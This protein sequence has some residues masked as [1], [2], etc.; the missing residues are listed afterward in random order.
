MPEDRFGK[1]AIELGLVTEDQLAD[2]VEAM[3]QLADMG[4]TE[5]L[6]TIMVKKGY[7]TRD[8]VKQVLAAQGKRTT[9]TIAGYE[10]EAKIGQGAMGAVYRA[11]QTSMD[12]TVALKVLPPSLARDK[13][14]TD[15][16]LTEARA[17]ARLNHPNIIQ[18]IDVGQA[19]KYYYFAMEYVDGRTVAERLRETGPMAEAEAVSVARQVAEALEHASHQGI[20]HR[21]IKPDNIMITADGMAKLCDLGLAKRGK[22]RDP[23][24]EGTA[25]GTPHY[26]SPEQAKGEV[27]VDA[28]SDIYSLG[29]TLY[30]MLTGKPPFEGNTA[31]VVMTKHLTE[32]LPNPQDVRPDLSDGAC[33]VIE[34]MMAKDPDDRYQWPRDLLADLK[35][36]EAGRAP[37]S[38][39]VEAGR[40]SVMRAAKRRRS[41]RRIETPPPK[42]SATPFIAAAAGAVM[43]LG[44]VAVLFWPAKPED[45]PP[46]PRPPRPTPVVEKLPPKP[47]AV[48]AATAADAA[49]GMFKAAKDYAD[50]HPQ[51]FWSI[52]RRYMQVKAETTGTKYSLMADDEL[53]SHQARQKRL[54]DER[55]A[56]C[57]QKSGPLEA[58]D[59]FAEAKKLFEGFQQDLLED[60]TPRASFFLEKE[61]RRIDVAAKRRHAALVK[62]AAGRIK[63]GKLDEAA[64]LIARAKRI[65]YPEYAK[66]IP[67][68]E[69]A[70]SDARK[71]AGAAAAAAAER[72][73]RA[74]F[75]AERNRILSLGREKR[76]G[77]ALSATDA[78]LANLKMSKW[79][80]ELRQIES[81]LKAVVDRMK[82][83]LEVLGERARDGKAVTIHKRGVL[84]RNAKIVSVQG[85][86][87]TVGLRAMGQTTLKLTDLSAKDVV[88]LT[89]LGTYSQ[90]AKFEYGL[91]LFF[92][93]RL[94]QAKPQ[95]QRASE[96]G[97]Y[98]D[99]AKYFL[100]LM[101]AESREGREKRAAEL[102]SEARAHFAAERWS[103]AKKLLQELQRD[104]SDTDAYKKNFEAPPPPPPPK[105]SGGKKK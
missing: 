63:A 80:P 72:Q 6:G 66:A 67:P 93:G 45:P 85:T 38:A 24:A 42:G 16:F 78:A 5:R 103:Q 9:A 23:A 15:R 59:R 88:D 2:S 56:D 90:Q 77:E 69:K 84:Y 68:L 55:F 46:A 28:R 26:I 32:E 95:L 61:K 10:I 1:V 36:L 14:F 100:G 104:Y 105:K 51:E 53:K 4:L 21:D 11:R 34:N 86:D 81:S 17:A 44:I 8:Q 92:E 94:P 54:R 41:G 13:R 39:R 40:S 50:K 102:L 73:A 18:G 91:L 7:L 47:P 20:V 48:P 65:G 89:G 97:A 99:E 30:H 82:K 71:A 12:R 43:V 31:A 37:A 70:I 33:H 76:F 58:E 75:L 60:D 25:V 87:V 22:Y 96:H 62:D 98:A 79:R 52:F 27:S 83:L 49:E 29:A 74:D 19:G 57:R 101:E 3:K 64:G 35:N